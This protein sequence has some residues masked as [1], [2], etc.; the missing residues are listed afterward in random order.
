[1]LTTRSLTIMFT[2]IVGYTAQT[3]Q[4]SRAEQLALL[5]RHDGLLRPLIRQFGGT[6]VK[7]LGDGLLVTFRSATMGLRCAMA[8]QDALAESNLQQPEQRQLHLRI[9][10]AAG[11]V[12]LQQ[13]D[14]FGE[15]VSIASRIEG[16]TPPDQ[17]YFAASVYLAMNKAEIAAELVARHELKGIPVPV[18]VFR[19]VPQDS[20]GR[21]LAGDSAERVHNVEAAATGGRSLKVGLAAAALACAVA[22]LAWLVPPGWLSAPLAPPTDTAQ[23]FELPTEP[24]AAGGDMADPE[25][26]IGAIEAL[27]EQGE[28]E[29][30]QQV[31]GDLLAASEASAAMLLAQGHLAFATRHRETGADS[32]RKALKLDAA[33]AENPRL[34]ANLVS[35]LGWETQL[36][37]ELLERY[38]SAA[39]IE[40]LAVRTAAPGYWGR[41][42]AAQVL[43]AIGQGDRIQRVE[44]ALLDLQEGEDCEQR[45]EAVRRLGELGGRKAL[46]ALQPI[47]EMSLLERLGS[48]NACLVEAARAAVADIAGESQAA[49]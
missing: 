9:G 24:T 42:H 26:R 44:A 12:Q 41:L 2:D 13:H 34:A 25:V 19:V 35:A 43:E 10:L 29:I 32:Y 16:M 30:A 49:P 15:A 31:L 38:R 47:A 17:I 37:R 27:L 14:V 22:L 48:E 39:M 21:Y 3:A 6:L 20:D 33:L 18:E 7:S 23:V 40:A 45:R 4:L 1:M 28:V 11:D 46:A 8:I 5:R 36:A